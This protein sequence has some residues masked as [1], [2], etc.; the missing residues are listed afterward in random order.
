[1]KLLEKIDELIESFSS[2]VLVGVVFGM[3]FLSVLAI[4]LRWFEI[5]VMGLDSLVRHLVFLSAFLG[6]VL[7]TGRKTHI[8]IDILAKYLEKKGMRAG[9]RIVGQLVNFFSTA[10]LI[11][12][13]KASFDF[14]MVE[15]KYAKEGFLG[16][17]SG[18]LVG[19]I[20]VGFALIAFRFFFLFVKS[21]K[22]DVS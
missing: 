6:G 15:W 9:Q 13:V 1:M 3:L 2:K 22:E 21:C 5:S 14:L 19:I 18:H 8:A 17:H 7:A 11:W 12:L 16:L 20:P 10:T 4:V